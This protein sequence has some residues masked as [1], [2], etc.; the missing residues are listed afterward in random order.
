[1]VICIAI[2][3]YKGKQA[4][5]KQSNSNCKYI[6][7]LEATCPTI[8][9]HQRRLIAMYWVLFIPRNTTHHL[10]LYLYHVHGTKQIKVNHVFVY[11]G[12]CYNLHWSKQSIILISYMPLKII[13]ILKISRSLL[14]P[15]YIGPTAVLSTDF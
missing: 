14:I 2:R 3:L 9:F 6:S 5:A 10:Y 11:H 13:Y 8:V 4:S 15:W 12:C 1:M 7:M